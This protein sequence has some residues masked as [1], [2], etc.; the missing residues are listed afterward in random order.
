[1]LIGEP[2]GEFCLES[3]ELVEG[4]DPEWKAG[5]ADPSGRMRKSEFNVARGRARE[6]RASEES[7]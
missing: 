4:V 6:G 3:K 7:A 5:A 1:M 2:V